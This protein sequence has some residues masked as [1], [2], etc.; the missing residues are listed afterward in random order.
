[1]SARHR[2][3]IE[4][5]KEAQMRRALFLLAAALLASASLAAPVPPPKTAPSVWARGWDEPADPKGDCRFERKF[6]A[7]TI[8]VPGRGHAPNLLAA[9]RDAPRLMREADGDFTFQARVRGNFLED[10]FLHR[11]AGLLLLSGPGGAVLEV[12]AVFEAEGGRRHLCRARLYHLLSSQFWL[13]QPRAG[14]V[15]LRLER[16]GQLLLMSSSLD[17]REWEEVLDGKC[18]FELPRKVKVGVFASSKAEGRFAATFDQL[19]FTQ[20]PRPELPTPGSN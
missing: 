17:G 3:A 14:P 7:L 10:N 13:S 12:G 4:Q 5:D 19:K 6:G 9:D 18:G 11:R 15:H 1:V 16:R 2:G 8:T 20:K